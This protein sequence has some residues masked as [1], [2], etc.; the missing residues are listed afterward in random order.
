MAVNVDYVY[1]GTRHTSV[2]NNLNLTYNPA[3]GANYPFTDRNSRV[4]PSFGLVNGS[5]TNGYVNYHALETA[6]TKRFSQRWQASGT[7]TLSVLKD[8]VG[9]PGFGA[10]VTFPVA[11]DIGNYYTLSALDTRHRAVLNG[12]WEVGHG[13]QVSGLLYASSGQRFPTT[14]G[15]FLRND[16]FGGTNRLRPNGTIVPRNNFV[17]D[18]L[19]RVDLRMG[20]R[21]PLGN[22]VRLE[23]ILEVY[24][25]FNQVNYGSY[26]TVE[27]SPLYGQPSQVNNVAF[28]PRTA[29]LG[30]R[31][32]F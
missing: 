27:T 7:Y 3:T 29:Q 21:I 8:G 11:A 23:G 2:F 5:L 16:G 32:T 1:N 31:L 22:R 19:H 15:G 13:F 4:D 10:P 18:P 17:G 14:Y 12:I 25:A 30:F 26:V 24:N 20:Q 9:A 6:F 28:F